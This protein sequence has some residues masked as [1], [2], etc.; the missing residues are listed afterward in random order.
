MPSLPSPVEIATG[1]PLIGIVAAVHL[2]AGSVVARAQDSSNN[3][4]ARFQSVERG[5]NLTPGGK[6]CQVY[7]GQLVL[8]QSHS[9]SRSLQIVGL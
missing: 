9:C 2:A 1:Y 3:G 5:I 4:L 8:K 6:G 7:V